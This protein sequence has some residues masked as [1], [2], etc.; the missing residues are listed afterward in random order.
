MSFGYLFLLRQTD[1]Q[2]E[3]ERKMQ[4]KR[5][6]V[7]EKVKFRQICWKRKIKDQQNEKMNDNLI[8]GRQICVFV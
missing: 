1:R 2:T 7:G 8:N 4:R 3:T 6:R 5:D